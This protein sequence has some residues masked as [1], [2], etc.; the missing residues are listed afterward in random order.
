MTVGDKGAGEKEEKSRHLTTTS[1]DKYKNKQCATSSNMQHAGKRNRK[2]TRTVR[3][4][5]DTHVPAHA[6]DDQL[7][8]CETASAAFS[9]TP[10]HC[11]TA[12]ARS[13]RISQRC[14]SRSSSSKKRILPNT[15][16][17]DVKLLKHRGDEKSAQRRAFR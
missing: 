16:C 5:K 14:F 6:R 9:G 3:A 17:K 15:A 12:G 7:D 2:A 8:D 1:S 13:E 4:K 10:T 11:K